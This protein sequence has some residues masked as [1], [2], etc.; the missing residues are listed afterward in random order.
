MATAALGVPLWFSVRDKKRLLL[1]LFVIGWTMIHLAFIPD[2][3]YHTPLI[4]IFCLWAA[5][6]LVCAWEHV[7]ARFAGGRGL[8]VAEDP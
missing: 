5:A 6:A 2:G 8:T 3:R 1:V 4:P 7:M